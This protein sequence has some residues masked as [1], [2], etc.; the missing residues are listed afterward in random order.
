MRARKSRLFTTKIDNLRNVIQVTCNEVL[1]GVR[2]VCSKEIKENPMSFDNVI[3]SLAAL[4]ELAKDRDSLQVG[5]AAYIK[6]LGEQSPIVSTSHRT[7]RRLYN[8]H[9]EG[10]VDAEIQRQFDR[11]NEEKLS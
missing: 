6:E 8:E 2:C 9:G 3:L 10:R 11:A 4:H 1:L 7:L 5:V